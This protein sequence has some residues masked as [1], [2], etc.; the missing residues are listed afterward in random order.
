MTSEKKKLLYVLAFKLRLVPHKF[1]RL[2]CWSGWEG[3]MK[4]AGDLGWHVVHTKFHE[5]L[6][7]Y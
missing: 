1:Q 2:Q 4:Y 3:F 6:V 5:D 7:R